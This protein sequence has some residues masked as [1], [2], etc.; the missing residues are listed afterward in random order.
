MPPA[1]RRRRAVRTTR[2]GHAAARR[3]KVAPAT[4]PPSRA[5]RRR[6]A[7]VRRGR[8]AL[9]AAVVVAVAVVVAWFPASA[10]Y[11]QR[12]AVNAT[13]AQLQALRAQDRAL[14]VEQQSLSLPA[15]IERL[16]RQ[17]YQLVNPGQQA[18]QVLEPN[19]PANSGSSAPFAGDP[20]LQKPVAPSVDG[21][22]PPGALSAATTT[23]TVPGH[24][25]PSS[26]PTTAPAGAPAPTSFLGR[27]VQTLEFWR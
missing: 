24:H 17:Q 22:L 19:G 6:A 21:L 25:G 23:T 7:Q 12:A 13:A 5:E 15:E 26:P 3:P 14:A 27:L 18:Y 20:G 2:P 9:V 1:D 4:G 8:V 16:A 11:H 10:L